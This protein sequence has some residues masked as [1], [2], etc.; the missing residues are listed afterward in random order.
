MGQ[1]CWLVNSFSCSQS[2]W[3]LSF[4]RWNLSPSIQTWEPALLGKLQEMWR[5]KRRSPLTCW[6][7]YRQDKP[8]SILPVETTLFPLTLFQQDNLAKDEDQVIKPLDWIPTASHLW[9]PG[10]SKLASA[11]ASP[12]IKP[13]PNGTF[14]WEFVGFGWV[15]V[16]TTNEI[17]HKWF[18]TTKAE[19]F[20][21]CDLPWRKTL[22]F[23]DCFQQREALYHLR[24]PKGLEDATVFNL[25]TG[26]H[27]DCFS[28][29]NC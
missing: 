25:M 19:I 4:L 16:I 20:P 6:L 9:E 15:A 11:G 5:E 24:S 21:T 22:D 12:Y 28:L 14:L 27:F 17:L 26:K 29:W 2:Y 8:P 1:F 7:N 13:L 10:R 23:T 18:M 3:L